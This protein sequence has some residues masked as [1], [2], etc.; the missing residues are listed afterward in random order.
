MD[1]VKA[2]GIVHDLQTTRRLPPIHA[3]YLSYLDT[4]ARHIDFTCNDT[5]SSFLATDLCRWI[6]LTMGTYKKIFLCGLSLSGLAAAFTLL[7]HSTVF[8]GALCQ[9]P[10]AWWSDEW[11]VKSLMVNGAPG[12]RFWISV[13]DRE[14]Q[15]GVTH[16]PTGLFQKTSQ[17]GSVRRL[18]EKLS[19]CN[20][21]VRY[22][23]FPGGHDP[24]C[25]AAELPQ[26]LPWLIQ[27]A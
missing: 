8:S 4:A 11:L 2:P 12:S 3:V 20:A 6:E 26:A 23:E 14:V 10:S 24:A 17:I 19:G 27:N 16:P 22:N 5:Y 18:A 25:W 15:E 13:G 21:P 9:S 1:R 7:R